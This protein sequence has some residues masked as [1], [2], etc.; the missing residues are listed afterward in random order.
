MAKKKTARKPSGAGTGQ[1]PEPAN[2]KQWNY[3]QI[4]AMRVIHC[5]DDEIATLCNCT[6]KTIERAKRRDPL[7]RAAY[8]QGNAEGRQTL[9]RAQAHA[10]YKGNATMLV[11]LGKQILGQRDVVRNEMTGENGEPIK[12]ANADEETASRIAA[13][14]DAARTRRAD[15]PSGDAHNVG[16]PA[17]PTKPSPSK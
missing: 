11:W 9:R 12:F 16:T 5:S 6:T 10:A 4:R 8:E 2:K 15:A 1:P 3:D 13:L 14:L 17:R 7:F